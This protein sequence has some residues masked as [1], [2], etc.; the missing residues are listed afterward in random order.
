MSEGSKNFIF[1]TKPSAILRI[2]NFFLIEVYLLH[3]KS[4]FETLQMQIYSQVGISI[5]QF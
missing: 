5:T 2:L 3:H 1:L 4:S